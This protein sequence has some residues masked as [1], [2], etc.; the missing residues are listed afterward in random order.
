MGGL[1]LVVSLGGEIPSFCLVWL[2]P[3]PREGL[4][5]L[6]SAVILGGGI[7]SRFGLAGVAGDNLAGGN[8]LVWWLQRF[9]DAS[10]WKH[11]LVNTGRG[12]CRTRSVTIPRTVW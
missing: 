12:I 6:E 4:G 3:V 10:V 7:P 1:E 9:G 11:W 2:V 5:G 8:I